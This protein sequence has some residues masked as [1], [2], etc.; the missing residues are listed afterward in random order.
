MPL[1]SD[2]STGAIAEEPERESSSQTATALLRLTELLLNG[3][4]QPGERMAEVPLALRLNVSRTP[5]R[6]ALLSRA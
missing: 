6:L 2:E 1:L 4:L 3:E 5:L